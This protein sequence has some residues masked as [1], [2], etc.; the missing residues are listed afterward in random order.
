MCRRRF[1]LRE[2]LTAHPPYLA[3]PWLDPR[4]RA[5]VAALVDPASG[6]AR[7]EAKPQGIVWQEP[8][9]GLDSSGRTDLDTAIDTEGRRTETRSDFDSAY[10]DW[11]SLVVSQQAEDAGECR[12]RDGAARADAP[13]YAAALREAEARGPAMSDAAAL[14]L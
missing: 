4:L 13:E 5:H 6:L 1:T 2:R 3:E 11:G 9:G 12:A 7:E 10:G 8:D 14:V